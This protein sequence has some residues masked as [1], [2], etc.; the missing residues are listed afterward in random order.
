MRDI[1]K[2]PNTVLTTPTKKVTEIDD[3]LIDLLDEM[4]A[5]MLEKDGIGLAANQ[6]GVSSRVAI[7]HI[8]D[9]SGIFEMI[10]PEIIKKSG[11]T[12]DVEGCLSFPEVYGTVERF[13]DIT[14]RFVD[15]EGYEV[16]V[17]ASDY[18]SR[19][20]QHEI[21]HLDGG[22]FIDKI[23]KRLSPDEL[24]DYMEEHGYD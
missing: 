19:V 5:I 13:D 16:E 1:I 22:L 18:L 24:I 23:I 17:E 10:N 2:Y 7:V 9:E 11:K 8:D 3:E 15:R 14:V 4:H 20:M 6:V 12:I 21:E